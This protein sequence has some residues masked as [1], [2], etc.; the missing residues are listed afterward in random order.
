MNKLSVF[1][2]KLKRGEA[3]CHYPKIKWGTVCTPVERL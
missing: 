1:I 3:N 2:E